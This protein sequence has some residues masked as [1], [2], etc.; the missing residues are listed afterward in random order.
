MLARS[1]S[2]LGV[3]P[4]EGRTIAPALLLAF[5]A[6]GAM[7]LSTIAADTLFVSTFSLGQL[8]RFF[9][10]SSV[11]RF[12]VALAY[13]SLLRR[14]TGAR[15]DAAVI[16]ATAVSL[17]ACAL[18][19]G[20]GPASVYTVAL[21]ALLFPP[22]LPLV[23]FNAVS[24]CFHARQAKRL[25][26][27]VAAAST[28]GTIF[29]GAGASALAT[30]FGT[31]SLFW[32][33]ALLSLAAVP[34]PAV[35]HRR[36]RALAGESAGAAQRGE[37][38]IGL[39]AALRD[40][41]R[42]VR[43]V[44]VVRVVVMATVLMAAGTTFL[45][46]A[47]KASLKASYSQDRIAAFLGGFGVVSNGLVLV[48]QLLLTGR[49][50]ERFG[51]RAAL[52]AL[53]AAVLASGPALLMA[54]GLASA[55]AAKGAET[56]LRYA[57]SGSVSDLLLTPAPDDVRT[58]AKVLL[59]GA[60]GPVG[61][62]GSAVVLT[63]FGEAGPSSL[64][65]GSMVVLV[66]A[67][68]LWAAL[69]ARRAYTAVLSRAIGEGR[70]AI[71]VS[72]ASA[73]VLRAEL[74]RHLA[75][76]AAAAPADVG[77]PSD[78]PSASDAPAD[79]VAELAARAR[80]TSAPPAPVARAPE[81][82]QALR[83]LAIMGDRYFAIDDVAPALRSR[84]VTVRRAAVEAALRVA[85]DASR[86]SMPPSGR[87]SLPP[88]ARASRATGASV[89]P[90]PSARAQSNGHGRA[91]QGQRLLE[92]SADE[93]DEEVE[94][95]ALAAARALGAVVPRD[96][97]QRALVKALAGGDTPQA[98]ALWAEALASMAQTDRDPAVKQL[99]K[100]AIGP[101]SPRRA[102]ALR[103][104]GELRET[105]AE[106]EILRAMGSS[107]AAVFADAARA[108]VLID[109]PGAV[110]TLVMR[111][112][113]GP[114]VRA[115]GAALSLAGPTA[116]NELL[117]ALPT[118]RGDA[119]IAPTAVASGR[120]IA[121]TIRAA[122]VLARLGPEACVRVLDRFG[123]LG[124]RARNAVARAF[125]AVPTRYG[126]AVEP[127]PV[128]RAMDL[129]VAYSESL[130]DAYRHS[131]AGLLRREIAHRLGET[132]ERV[133]DLASVIGDRDLIERARAALARHER[134][135]GHG[136]EL[137]ENVLPED[138]ALRIV[139]VLE[140]EQRTSDGIPP[141]LP[142]GTRRP[143]FDGWLEKCRMFDDK[144]L[145]L[146]AAMLGVLEKVLIL[147]DSSLFMGLSGEELY[148]VAEIAQ[149]AM[150]HAGDVVI[151]QG[152]PGDALFVVARGT[153]HAVKGT[154]KLR[155]MTAGDA[156]GE[157]ALLDGAPRA[158]TVVASTEAQLLRIPRQE[159]EAL[160]DE[161]PE[162]ARGV[163]RTLIK[164]LRGT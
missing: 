66:G 25:L 129:T 128:M 86:A 142:T 81:T 87:G 57:F 104:L 115:A 127:A 34:L 41:A 84:S 68:G 94:R 162:L 69:D 90:P 29:V 27:L 149:P 117:A 122:R 20:G 99:R 46:F 16:V 144:E 141:S 52:S 145:V 80:G 92:L 103:A 124:Y 163:I 110:P 136:L 131:R 82:E 98:I 19:A 39:L 23:A 75:T 64:A 159:F 150:F 71:D 60:A 36:A 156:F 9:V 132:A 14:W 51:V 5:L 146:E 108:A 97:A 130:I 102:A 55:A 126:R 135:R 76:N 35:L 4:G 89:P 37:D 114:H 42:D 118:T 157:L 155:E 48:A 95:A 2:L 31:R 105:R 153:V 15:A 70:L 116:V 158:A 72:P 147:R 63:A 47:F 61:Y 125:S 107:D 18:V 100:A 119:A 7:S 154:A 96:R 38:G 152:D 143:A 123:D 151:R 137:L 33:G 160:L 101:D 140:Y 11:V 24:G 53:P 74:A 12:G 1:L 28:V 32:A 109:A 8:S 3:R 13:G 113:T 10:V 161:S 59:K 44:P 43:E 22:L 111:L 121:G 77:R 112:M 17:A 85:P 6:V 73:A 58:R 62:A 93:G 78:A 45:D 164:H 21:V 106:R 139:A 67:L 26:P 88:S 30:A 83:T 56:V 54:P 91:E 134:D 49:F 133:L 40:T 50:I 148:P 138:L 120:N 65:L 79:R